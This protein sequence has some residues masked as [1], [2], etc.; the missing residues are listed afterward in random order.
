MKKNSEKNKF[1][2]F[3]NLYKKIQSCEFLLINYAGRSASF[4]LGGLLDGNSNILNFNPYLDRKVLFLLDEFV[5]TK[6]YSNTEV[7]LLKE[8]LKKILVL[9]YEIV[10]KKATTNAKKI[11]EKIKKVIHIFENLI[12]S[13]KNNSYLNLDTILKFFYFSYSFSFNKKFVFSKKI[14]ILVNVHGLFPL[15]KQI[16]FMKKFKK[17]KWITMIRDPLKSIDSHYLHTYGR[18]QNAI[19]ALFSRILLQYKLSLF[20]LYTNK[21]SNFFKIKAYEKFIIWN[22]FK[23]NLFYIFLVLVAE[24]SMIVHKTNSSI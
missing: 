9:H 1:K 13:N 17:Y 3:I 10:Y 4:F 22:I 14:K 6:D 2:K 12:Y 18:E 16:A 23:N 21:S 19:Q 5:D 7:H 24:Y 8:K 20:F 11:H 15:E